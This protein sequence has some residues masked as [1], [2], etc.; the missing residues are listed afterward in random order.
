MNLFLS[1][2][3]HGGVADSKSR[4]AASD[5]VFDVAESVLGDIDDVIPNKETF[6]CLFPKGNAKPQCYYRPGS[7]TMSGNPF[8][9]VTCAPL[10]S[11]TRLG[12]P[13]NSADHYKRRILEAWL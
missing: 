2:L 5:A 4:F 1:I 8:A 7:T 11:L 6:S 3:D 10:I 12:S 13:Q 9:N